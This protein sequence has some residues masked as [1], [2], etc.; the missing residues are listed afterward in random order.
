MVSA[1]QIL[2]MMDGNNYAVID[3]IEYNNDN[4]LYICG[5][6]KDENPTDEYDIVK[7]TIEE[8]VPIL[9]FIEDEDLYENLKLAFLSRNGQSSND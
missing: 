8:G 6:D 5:V 4:Y 1:N 7:E 9:D 2:E 3:K